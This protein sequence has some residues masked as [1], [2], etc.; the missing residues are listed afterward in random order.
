[1]RPRELFNAMEGQ[2]QTDEYE[3]KQAWER[4]RYMA[5]AIVSVHVGKKD[6]SELDRAFA[7]PWDSDRR[8]SLSYTAE[9]FERMEAEARR[10]AQRMNKQIQKNGVS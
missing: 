10:D 9:D 8:G 7:L 3:L 1:M 6:R 5:K 4:A 2:R